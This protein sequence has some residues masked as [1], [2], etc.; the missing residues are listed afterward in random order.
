MPAGRL[1]RYL[2][3]YSNLTTVLDRDQIACY[4]SPMTNKTA[5]RS[6]SDIVINDDAW[7]WQDDMIVFQQDARVDAYADAWADDMSDD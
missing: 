5:P 6:L 4:N 7:I 2:Q 3:G 1:A